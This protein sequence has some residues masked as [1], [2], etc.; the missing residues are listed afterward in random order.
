M[1]QKE[2]QDHILSYKMHFST[3]IG[4][5]VLTIM[6]VTVSVFGADI[7]TLSVLTALV[8]ASVKAIVVGMYFMHLKWEPRVYQIMIGIV[9]VLF[10]VFVILTLLDYM[11]RPEGVIVEY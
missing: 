4:L 1:A 8:I 6:T 5:L 11:A 9:L 3:W 2:G 7:Y 10:L